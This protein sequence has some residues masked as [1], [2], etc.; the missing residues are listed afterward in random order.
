M[1]RNKI[2]LWSFVGTLNYLSVFKVFFQ[3]FNC[4]SSYSITLPG[5]VWLLA[6]F[7]SDHSWSVVGLDACSKL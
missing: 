6:I 7:A 3:L 1:I 5:S 4:R 2:Q